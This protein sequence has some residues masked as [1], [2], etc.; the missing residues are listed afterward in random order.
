MQPASSG[1][2]RW[3]AFAG[4]IKEGDGESRLWL[5]ECGTGKVLPPG[6]LEPTPRRWPGAMHATRLPWCARTA[7]EVKTIV[8]GE[9]QLGS[10]A[11]CGSFFLYGV[12]TPISPGELFVSGLPAKTSAS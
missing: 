8:G 4:S 10:F 5:L 11:V 7:A 6:D 1:D 3:I 12:D 9:R 2:G